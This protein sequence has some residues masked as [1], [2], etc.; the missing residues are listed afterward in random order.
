MHPR[1]TSCAQLVEPDRGALPLAQARVHPACAPHFAAADAGV[2]L[3]CASASA[4]AALSV[5]VS[6][7]FV[8][9]SAAAA[10]A[11]PIEILLRPRLRNSGDAPLPLLGVRVPLAFSGRVRVPTP[12]PRWVA[13]G[14]DEWIA[15]CWGGAVTAPDGERVSGERSPCEYAALQATP[16]GGAME[17]FFSGGVLCAGCT[18]AGGGADGTM[19]A[20]KHDSMLPMDAPPSALQPVGAAACDSAQLPPPPRFCGLLPDA[21]A[22]TTAVQQQQ[23]AARSVCPPSD[24]LL[25]SV[26]ALPFPSAPEHTSAAVAAS[27]DDWFMRNTE[28]RLVLNV[29]NAG[30]RPLPLR[31]LRISLS[32]GYDVFAGPTVGWLR[33]PPSEFAFSCWYG[34]AVGPATDG[35]DACGYTAVLPDAPPGAELSYG[36]EGADGAPARVAVTFARG[37]LCPGCSLSGGAGGILGVWHHVF[38][39]PQRTAALQL[40]AVT[41]ADDDGGDADAPPQ[42]KTAVDAPPAMQ[43][44]QVASPPPP[45][46]ASSPPP[47]PPPPPPRPSAVQFSPLNAA[48]AA[49]GAAADP[50]AFGA[51]NSALT[52]PRLPPLLQRATQQ[53]QQAAAQAQQLGRQQL[54]ARVVDVMQ[55]ATPPSKQQPDG[56][57]TPPPP[58]TPP[59]ACPWWRPI[60]C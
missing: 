46:A 13:A 40:L 27:P 53:L 14:G 42:A 54:Q 49:A 26:T 6:T 23:Q 32:Y 31:A 7:A 58:A 57:Q 51:A 25:V 29:T 60:N 34:A 12:T 22:S 8:L 18:L 38:F 45:Q 48:A 50:F 10:S 41:C 5:A 52:P 21:A 1:L 15:D 17:L 37:W 36:A 2:P 3:A 9:P 16:D 43:L 28:L 20:L 11:L 30:S 33:R 56:I 47:P 24:Q 4:L 55:V 59:K 35:E 19:F 39:M 44:E